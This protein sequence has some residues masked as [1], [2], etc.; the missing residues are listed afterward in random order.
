MNS[1]RT[2]VLVCVCVCGYMPS[3]SDPDP[4]EHATPVMFINQQL[5]NLLVLSRE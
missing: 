5:M 1:R 3:N 2:G 4:L